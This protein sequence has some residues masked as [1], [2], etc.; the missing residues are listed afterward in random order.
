M[1]FNI[2]N[3]NQLKIFPQLSFLE[4]FGF[5][6]AGGTA[7]AL[8]IGHR[9]SLDFDF[10]NP[11]H[12]SSFRLYDKIE[13]I[14]K[15]SAEKISQHRDTLF[16]R[17]NGVDLS[18]FWYSHKLI[19]NPVNSQGILLASLE[20]IAAMKLIA[21]SSRPAQRDYIDIFYLLN[22]FTIREMFAF[23]YKKYPNFNHYLSLRALT[24]SEDLEDSNKRPIKV[25]DP[26]YSWQKAKDKIFKEVKKYQLSTLKKH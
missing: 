19:E 5:Y 2:L 14:F 6:L 12:F 3:K 25:L 9:T 8:Q 4:K 15:Y 21:I 17:A 20:D 24:Y 10:Y 22:K 26:D 11:K 7:C 16:C 1:Y 18:F 13:N 23:G